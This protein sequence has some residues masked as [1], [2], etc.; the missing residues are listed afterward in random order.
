MTAC[1]R[2]SPLSRHEYLRRYERAWREF[3]SAF[4]QGWSNLQQS[5]VFA[6]LGAEGDIASLPHVRLLRRMGSE[7]MPP[8]RYARENGAALSPWIQDALLL[9]V[10]CGHRPDGPP[11]RQD[12]RL[13]EHPLPFARIARTAG[14]PAG[15]HK[16]S[17]APAPVAPGSHRPAGLSWTVRGAAAHHG[18][19]GP[20]ADAGPEAFRQPQ[21]HPVGQSV[22]R[23]PQSHE[24]RGAA[25][26]RAAWRSPLAADRHAGLPAP[27]DHRAGRGRRAAQVGERS[28]QQPGR[29]CTRGTTSKPCTART[30][31][32]PRS[33]AASSLR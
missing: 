15:I 18:Q 22:Q 8:A 1:G 14:L 25:P 17:G 12:P 28:P 30:A 24:G 10:L 3:A 31:S 32:S 6:A 7:L 5:E 13:A 19:P 2:T 4:A 21:G 11:E 26:V 20:F 16:G 23:G 27:G 29:P 33:W 9:Q